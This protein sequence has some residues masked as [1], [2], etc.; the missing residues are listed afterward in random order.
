MNLSSKVLT[1]VVTGAS[2]GIGRACALDLAKQ[3]CR[4]F[5]GV[6]KSMDGDELR[7]LGGPN[8]IPVEIDVTKTATIEA[9]RAVVEAALNGAGLDGLVNNAGI[10]RTAP[11]EFVTDRDMR[12]HFEVNVF[13]QVAM[14]QAFLPLIHRGR[15]RIVNVG[16]IGSDITMPF[17]GALCASKAALTSLTHALRLELRPAGIHVCLV[18][19]GAISTPGVDKTLGDVEAVI[20]AIPPQGARY[21]D[22]LR[23]FAKLAHARESNGSPPEVVAEAI[24]HA[25]TA[26]RPRVRYVVGKHAVLLRTL[27]RVAPDAALDQLRL[28][29]FGFST[30]F[31]CKA[32]P[33]AERSNPHAGAQV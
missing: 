17:G 31:G 26:R 22:E 20:R 23:A 10:A 6:R 24:R 19:P 8:V 5:A 12:D 2:S 15:G 3:G 14:T 25:L 9:A 7:R 32:A 18:E 33:A 21:A 28:R 30:E 1:V 29:L 4:V 16:S 11:V 27:S 13:G